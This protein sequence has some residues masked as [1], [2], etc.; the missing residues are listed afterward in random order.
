MLERTPISASVNDALKNLVEPCER[1]DNVQAGRCPPPS[2]P[3][4]DLVFC[5]PSW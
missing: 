2:L 1:I 5:S 3:V 4:H